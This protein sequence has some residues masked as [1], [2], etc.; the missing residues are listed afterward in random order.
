[1]DSPGENLAI[2]QRENTEWTQYVLGRGR[3][4]NDR[5]NKVIELEGWGLFSG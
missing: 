2:M 5:L 4:H 3:G 1:M